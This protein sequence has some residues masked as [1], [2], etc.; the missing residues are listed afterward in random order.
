[1]DVLKAVCEVFDQVV[2]AIGQNASKKAMLSVTERQKLIENLIQDEQFSRQASVI[3]YDGLTTHAALA[4]NADAIVRGIRDSQDAAYELQLAGMNHTLEADLPT[5][6]VP[7]LP[8]HRSISGTL[9]RQ[10]W[11]MK[12]PIHDFVPAAVVTFLQNRASLN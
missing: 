10:V 4:C 7:A 9:V 5:F 6:L 11:S 2:I 3:L 8:A 12:G 1:M